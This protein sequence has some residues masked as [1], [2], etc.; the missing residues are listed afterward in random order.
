MEVLPEFQNTP[1]ALEHIYIKSP[2]TGEQVPLST[3][4]KWTT[5]HRQPSCRSITRGNFR[6]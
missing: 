3:L 1:Q 2:L 5:E 6:R 4:V